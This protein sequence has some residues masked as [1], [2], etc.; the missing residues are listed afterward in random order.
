MDQLTK[1]ETIAAGGALIISAGSFWYL[2]NKLEEGVIKLD[3][4]QKNF[5][6][7]IAKMSQHDDDIKIMGSKIKDFENLFG[8]LNKLKE[9][10]N[11]MAGELSEEF[12]KIK[13][14]IKK[15]DTYIQQ[16][17]DKLDVVSKHLG[18]KYEDTQ[19]REAKESKKKNSRNIFKNKPLKNNEL[20]RKS[21]LSNVLQNQNLLNEPEEENIFNEMNAIMNS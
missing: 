7:Q 12:T 15:Q 6:T 8:D 9:D 4:I 5:M 18:I 20:D 13:R 21:N 14:D 11:G 10:F 16:I 2:N 17:N 19:I 1:I 3:I